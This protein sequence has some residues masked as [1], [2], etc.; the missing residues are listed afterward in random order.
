MMF[1]NLRISAWP[2]IATLLLFAACGTGHAAAGPKPLAQQLTES[3]RMS[4]RQAAAACTDADANAFFDVFIQSAAVR[5][6][7]SAPKITFSLETQDSRPL[8]QSEIPGSRYRDFPIMM[9]DYYR[10]PVRPLRPGDD[11]EYVE[12]SIYKGPQNQLAVEWTRVHYDG[13][14]DGGDDL[15]NAVTLD[16]KPYDSAGPSDGQL[17]FRPAG[18]CWELVSDIRYKP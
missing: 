3:D 8:R 17:L 14:S 11:D 5:R 12:I 2:V 10:K 6:K 18:G 4:L 15:G 16:G 7:Y 1:N 9:V 13:R